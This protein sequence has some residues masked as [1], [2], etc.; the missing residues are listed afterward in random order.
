MLRVGCWQTRFQLVKECVHKS[1]TVI[2]RN[3]ISASP[4]KRLKS[5]EKYLE[6]LEEGCSNNPGPSSKDGAHRPNFPGCLWI[7]HIYYAQIPSRICLPDGDSSKGAILS[8]FWAASDDWTS[9][10]R[11]ACQCCARSRNA[12]ACVGQSCRVAGSKSAPFGQTNV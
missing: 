12:S 3:P 4:N 1:V 2:A 5:G 7:A 6:S 11:I 9:Q 10:V 8:N